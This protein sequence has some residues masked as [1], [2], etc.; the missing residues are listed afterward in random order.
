MQPLT[1]SIMIPAY[2]KPQYIF[3]AVQTALAQDYE[4]LEVIVSDDSTDNQ[5]ENV[6]RSFLTD[7]RF[8]YFKN[9]VSLGRVANYRKLLY[10]LARGEW[11]LMLDGDDYLTDSGYIQKAINLIREHEKLVLVGAGMKVITEASGK[12]DYYG[13]DAPDMIF[14]GKELFSTYDRLP[15][16]QTDIYPRAL[17]CQLDFYRDPSTASDSE[18]LYRLCLHGQVGWFRQPVAAWRVHDSNTTY[19]TQLDKQIRE[20]VFIDKVYRYACQF[21]D[22]EVAAKWRHKMYASMCAH[23]LNQ[24]FATKQ[25][26]HVLMIVARCWHY[27]GWKLSIVYLLRTIGL[28][29]APP[30]TK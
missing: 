10:E 19:H 7:N 18:S 11:V 24:A 20:L 3:Q 1:V 2:N 16:H 30:V 26:R 28:Y 9:R 29:K 17:A 6:L 27:I 13:L 15:A 21:L 4:H 23:L 25:Y 5:T 22:K 14:E 8:A 12:E